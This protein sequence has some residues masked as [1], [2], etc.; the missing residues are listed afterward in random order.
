MIGPHTNIAKSSRWVAWFQ[1]GYRT[2]L[3]LPVPVVLQFLVDHVQRPGPGD[4]SPAGGTLVH[5]LPPATEAALVAGG[6][7]G[8]LGAPALATV[9]RR[10]AVFS[11]AH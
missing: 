3:R 6:F 7:K 5:D 1:L 10:I 8:A 4:G 2:A 9:T 11:K